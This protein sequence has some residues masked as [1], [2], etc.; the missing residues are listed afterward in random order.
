MNVLM[1]TGDRNLLKE[2]SDAHKRLELQRGA[3]EALD[4]VYW[5]KGALFPAVPAAAYDVVTSQD[6]LWRGLVALK[7][8]R[9]LGAKL[10]IQVHMDLA[11]LSFFKR[12]L[13]RF[14]LR[15]ADTVRVVSEK[16]G[17]QVKQTGVRKISVLPVFVG[18]Q[19]F[20][21]IARR[22][23]TGKIILWIGRFE[24]EKDPRAAIEILKTV[25]KEFPDVK[26]TM[27]GSGSLGEELVRLAQ[28]LPVEFP[29]WQDPGAYL[30][31]A[32][33]VL[34]TSK[35]E[36]W[37][38]SIIE[39]LAAGVPVVAPDVGV[40]KEAGAFVVAR[41]DLAQAAAEILR[42]GASGLLKLQLLPPEA[43]AVQWRNSLI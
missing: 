24:D 29:G 9:R 27:L 42:E 40:A 7:L 20:S 36:S 34:C 38:A 18:T 5:G 6:P 14:V 17:A 22:P 4:V 23:H 26:L 10:N 21:A 33:L 39:A 41:Q 35:H 37:G 3:V 1:I 28:G 16:I 25:M 2:G 15:Y 13:A 32:D 43:W 12:M 11:A 19:I 31:T 30:E 8:A